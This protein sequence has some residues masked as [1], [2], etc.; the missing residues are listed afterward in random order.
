MKKLTKLLMLLLSHAPIATVAIA[1]QAKANEIKG[2]DQSEILKA[3][4]RAA[5]HRVLPDGH[6]TIGID[7]SA[8]RYYEMTGLEGPDLEQNMIQDINLLMEHGLIQ[9]DEKRIVSSGPSQFAM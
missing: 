4:V 9:L 1:A 7:A 8:R 5:R 6:T 3:M 2:Q